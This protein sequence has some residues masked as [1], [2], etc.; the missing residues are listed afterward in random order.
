M[1]PSPRQSNSDAEVMDKAQ[2]TVFLP[3]TEEVQ[4]PNCCSLCCSQFPGHT[5]KISVAFKSGEYI[6]AHDNA[7]VSFKNVP[8]CENCFERT[9]YTTGEKILTVVS[10]VLA[11]VAASFLIAWNY[12][13]A[14]FGIILG[15]GTFFGVFIVGST[16]LRKKSEHASVEMSI[17][18]ETKFVGKKKPIWIKFKFRNRK[19]AYMFARENNALGPHTCN[20]CKNPL[21]HNLETTSWYCLTCG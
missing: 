9:S 5:K 15:I 6:V 8:F 4:W 21:L 18:T 1:M 12:N 11:I 19:Y 16:M 3:R 13:Y 7:V 20:V 10:L 17:E 14:C 2:F